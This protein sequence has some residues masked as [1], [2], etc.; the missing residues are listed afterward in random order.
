MCYVNC[1]FVKVDQGSL[2]LPRSILVNLEDNKE[3]IQAYSTYIQSV[4]K[5]F[6]KGSVTDKQIA[7]DADAMI[8]FESALAKAISFFNKILQLI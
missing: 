8:H 5:A 2:A 1:S 3:I 7:D 6:V 4:A